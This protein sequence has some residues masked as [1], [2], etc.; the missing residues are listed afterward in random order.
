MV[1][2]MFAASRT[3][4]RSDVRSAVVHSVALAVACYVSYWF[5]THVLARAHFLS[6]GDELLGG[7][8]AVIATVFVYRT[9]YQGSVSA[10]FSRSAAT[11]LSFA[12]CLVYLS[13]FSFHPL[14][15]AVVIGL[16]TLVMMLLGRPDDVI[17]TGITSAVVL[18]VA[19]L[20]PHE[21]WEQPILRVFDTAVGIA[22]GFLAARIAF[23]L[24][25]G[26]FNRPAGGPDPHQGPTPRRRGVEAVSRCLQAIDHP[27][28]R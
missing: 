25:S 3:S 5:T 28:T 22:I 11:L 2:D 21:A 7:M 17:T 6:T 16:G 24:K 15:L 9:S 23:S 27:T 19:A 20:S 1:A 13:L 12:L 10:A 8:W 26:D 4:N 14:G 18:V